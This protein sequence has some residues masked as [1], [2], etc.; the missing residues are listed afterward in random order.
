MPQRTNAQRVAA[1]AAVPLFAVMD[2][3]ERRAWLDRCLVRTCPAGANII[4]PCQEADRFFAILAGRVKVFQLSAD[5]DEQ[6]FHLY[7]PG[8][9]F[10]EAA[11]FTGGRFP[12]FAEAVEAAELLV[13]TRGDLTKAIA[14]DPET[15]MHLLAGL[16]AKLREFNTLIEDL[17]LK[18]VPARLARVLAELSADGGSEQFRLPMTKRQLAA[19]LGTTPETLSRSLA[20]LR[21]LGAIDVQGRHITVLDPDA[22]A[23]AAAL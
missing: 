8:A 20:S 15:A 13:I 22:L 19:L 23:D 7:G 3:A 21:K 2:E 14:A 11:M 9:T 12:A 10:A 18:E 6:I 4:S 1:M 16:S 17:S 5:G